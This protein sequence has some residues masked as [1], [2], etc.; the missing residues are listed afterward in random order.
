MSRAWAQS[1][2]RC[3]GRSA[4]CDAGVMADGVGHRPQPRHGGRGAS[5]RFS[6]TRTSRRATTS[7]LTFGFTRE[8]SIGSTT[9]SVVHGGVSIGDG[10][11]WLHRVTPEREMPSPRGGTVWHGGL[12]SSSPDV[13]AHFARAEAAGAHIEREPTDQDY[14]CAST[15]HQR[16]GGPP[17]VVGRFA[18]GRLTTPRPAVRV[19]VA[20]VDHGRHLDAAQPGG[21][22]P[23]GRARDAWLARPPAQIR[24]S[25]P[26]LVAPPRRPVRGPGDQRA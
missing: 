6:S 13:D 2:T 24:G 12:R 4:A 20:T 9:E 23:G 21:R 17:V 11:V 1:S 8:G 26:P 25:R 7:R 3:S 5:A 14:G 18:A 19:T 10:V 16:P 15:A 22:V